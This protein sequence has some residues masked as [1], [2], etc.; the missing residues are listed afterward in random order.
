[1]FDWANSVYMLAISSTVFPIYFNESTRSAFGGDEIQFFGLTVVNTVLYSY[2]L[3]AGYVLLVLLSP[4][5][6]GIAD[7]GGL[8]K[9]MMRAFTL[10][11]SVACVLLFFF[12]GDNA[13]YGLL[14]KVLALIGYNGS[15]VFYNAYLPEIATPNRHDHLSARGYSLGYIGSVIQL[16]FCLVLLLQPQL[17]GITDGSLPARITLLFTGFWWL[18]FS[19]Y[20]F[21][22]LPKNVHKR[23]RLGKQWLGK[24]F[25]ELQQVWHSLPRYPKLKRYLLA[26]FFY[27]TGV[28]TVML[29]AATF[30]E[31][32]LNLG[33]DLLIGT[34]VG[35]Q[36]V[37][38]PGAFG[39][40]RLAKS[41]GNIYALSAMIA[42]WIAVSIAA[43]FVADAVS[44][45]LVAGVVG[46]VMGGIQSLSRSTYAK[47]LPDDTTDTASYFSFYDVC[48]KLSIVLGT[49]SFGLVEQLTGSMRNIVLVLVVFFALGFVLLQAGSKAKQ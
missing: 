32:E 45:L 17:F 19:L 27:S 6:S 43:Y 10:V 9:Q 3:S 25:Q 23:S 11:G 36:L 33:T 35:I 42:V 20:T 41:K 30:G 40:A 26:F 44:F 15:L 29:L 31:K 39:A 38:I 37:A 12:T 18:G 21:R 47:L 49:F 13:E 5:L 8:K 1:M 16:L 22:Y 24:G 2:A 46:L 28:Q 34:I 48:E 7:S 4:I 14:L